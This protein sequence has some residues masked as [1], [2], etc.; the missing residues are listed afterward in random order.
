MKRA[1]IAVARAGALDRI[2]VNLNVAK[3]ALDA[4]FEELKTLHN[5]GPEGCECHNETWEAV[6]ATEKAL[7]AISNL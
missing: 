6:R 2:E 1:E 4:A 7:E 3:H 5:P